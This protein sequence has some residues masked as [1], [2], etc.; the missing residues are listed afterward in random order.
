M[1]RE[2]D[3]D[4]RVLR[5]GTLAG[6][7]AVVTGAGSGIGRAVAV[8]LVELGAHVTGLGRHAD[9][10]AATGEAITGEAATGDG[11]YT[12]AVCDVRDHERAAATIA[13][14]GRAHGIDLL[15]NNAGG[16]F[17]AP[18]TR[19]SARGWAAVVD[20]NLT[21]VFHLTTAAYPYLRRSRG[22]VVN[23]S[24]SGVE[25]GGQGMAHAVAARA[26]VLGLTRTLALEWAGDGIRLNCLGPGTVLT[27]ALDAEAD[28]HVRDNLVDRATPL[29]RPT[30]AEE[31][32]ELV[33]F[34]AGPAAAMMTGQLV[35]LDGGAHL[36]PGLHMLAEAYR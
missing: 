19:I 33:A 5:A 25:R 24:L 27:A 17:F 36:G 2:D 29:R 14:V 4:V 1:T 13:E 31:V 6:R 23:M 15:V 8:R 26:G 16:Q 22:A 20:L 12:Y 30:R 21:S 11:R 9:T 28:R 18:A 34:L 10:L 7:H 32:A 3:S 35:Q